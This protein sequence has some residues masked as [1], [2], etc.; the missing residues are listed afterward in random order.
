MT[1]SDTLNTPSP[2][3]DSFRRRFV[4]GGVLLGAG[5]AGAKLL[6]L[7]RLAILAR[8]LGPEEFG[9]AALLILTLAMVEMMSNLSFDKAIIRAGD[10]RSHELQAS[11]QLLCAIRG[12]LIA[13]LL[14]ALAAPATAF[15]GI[16]ES[17]PMIQ[18]LALAP[19]I[20][21][22]AHL[23]PKRIQRELRYAPDVTIEIIAQAVVTLAAWPIAVWLD[24]ALA[25]VWL[26]VGRS[27]VHTIGTHIISKSPYRWSIDRRNT[28]HLLTFGAPLV[29]N[30]VLFFAIMQ[31][32]QLIIGKVMG[33]GELG[34]YAAVFG[35]I[36]AP[37]II[38]AKISISL[39][40]PVYARNLDKRA[41]F[42]RTHA[43]ASR[44]LG[45]IALT[46][47]CGSA[48]AGAGIVTLVYGSVYAP[49]IALVIAIA[50]AQSFRILRIAPTIAAIAHGDTANAMFANMLRISM[51]PAAVWLAMIGAPL[52]GI[53]LCG[54]A[55]ELLGLAYTSR[56]L[57]RKGQLTPD[58]DRSVATGVL[59]VLAVVVTAAIS[60]PGLAGS[61]SALILFAVG[62]SI[63]VSR[64]D[65]LR[66]EMV[67]AIEHILRRRS[68]RD[69]TTGAVA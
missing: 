12:V 63:L 17:A 27:C 51:L 3:N 2:A 31:G 15:L 69:A 5:H 14:F 58:A 62:I 18:W 61:A 11:S 43:L 57:S 64:W 19:L 53:A 20:T 35:L 36:S 59:C 38:L 21:G 45:L 1:T 9:L 41:T 65:D 22:F 44:G 34:L 56:R 28:A 40:L 46:L 52:W 55:G 48:A 29:V 60:I 16:P 47:A 67:H 4:R 42:E 33:L 8:L 37:T 7:V 50:V 10:R 68:I 25:A 39:L 54:A 30:G 6:S 32:D 13:A 49:G 23:E 24:S 26:I 66:I